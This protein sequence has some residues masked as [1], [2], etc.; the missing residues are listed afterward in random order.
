MAGMTTHPL[1]AWRDEQGLSQ[2]AAASQLEVLPMTLSRWERGRHMP[3]KKNWP[4]IEEVSGVAPAAL[5][6]HVK[7]EDQ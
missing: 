4:K 1:K 6:E 5:I 3:N 7:R 2:E